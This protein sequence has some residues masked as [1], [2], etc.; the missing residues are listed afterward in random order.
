[1]SYFDKFDEKFKY[2]LDCLENQ[3]GAECPIRPMKAFR[4]DFSTI[5]ALFG[6]TTTY[7]IIL[8][9]FKMGEA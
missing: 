8:L 9:Q 7:T 3:L 5:L 4:L 6:L 1:M 2:Q